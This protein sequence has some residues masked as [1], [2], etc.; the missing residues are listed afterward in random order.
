[1]SIYKKIGIGLVLAVA[2]VFISQPLPTSAQSG[3]ATPAEVTGCR[4]SLKF[5]DIAHLSCQINSAE[6]V[7][8]DANPSD[9]NPNYKPVDTSIFCKSGGSVKGITL[10]ISGSQLRTNPPSN[11]T[12]NVDLDVYDKSG[13]PPCRNTQPDPIPVSL[14]TANAKVQATWSGSNIESLVDGSLLSPLGSHDAYLKDAQDACGGGLIIILNSAGGSSGF[15]YT[16]VTGRGSPGQPVSAYP[17]LN[18]LQDAGSCKVSSKTPITVSGTQGAAPGGGGTGEDTNGDGV[19][20]ENDTVEE[21]TCESTTHGALAWLLCPLI[22]AA[23]TI[24]GE[25]DKLIVGQLVFNVEENLNS[26][27]KK[28]WS[29]VKNIATTIIVIAMLIMVISQAVSWG[30][31]DAY[32]VKKLL[33][34][35]VVVVILMQLSWAL[36]SWAIELSNDAGKG[37]AN[38]MFTPFGGIDQ[39][40]LKNIMSHSGIDTGTAALFNWGL[41]L[42]T[43]GL[44]FLNLPLL[45]LIAY[46]ALVAILIAFVVLIIRQAL[47]IFC[48]ILAPIALATWVLPGTSSYWKLW[49]E[50]FS[51]LLLMFPMIVGIIAAGRIFAWVAGDAGDNGTISFFIIVICV[52]APYVILPKTFQW[53]GR[54]LGNLAGS[55]NDRSKG[56]FDKGRE[57]LKGMSERRRGQHG[58]QYNPDASRMN[59]LYRRLGSGNFM[60]TKRSQRLAI[61]RGDA[62]RKEQDEMA[63]ASVRRGYEAAVE[64]GGI[65]AGKDYLFKQANA[66]TLNPRTGKR[67]KDLRKREAAYRTIIA[68]SSYDEIAKGSE[69]DTYKVD[70]KR[71]DQTKEWVTV[72]NKNRDLLSNVQSNRKDLVPWML[73]E[74]GK[75]MTQTVYD[76]RGDPVEQRVPISNDVRMQQTIENLDIQSL[77]QQNYTLHDDVAREARSGN[78]ASATALKNFLENNAKTEGGRLQLANFF[79]GAEKEGHINNALQALD[80]DL[81]LRGI[82]DASVS[83]G[84]RTSTPSPAPSPPRQQADRG[85]GTGPVAPPDV[86]NPPGS[87]I[88]PDEGTT[89]IDHDEPPR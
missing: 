63:E 47:I 58:E 38:L 85:W 73:P 84:V 48:V 27:V 33:P 4:Q 36:F 83:S 49:H 20:D 64:K 32:T 22:T 31:F 26:E 15:Q 68:T 19:V 43:V 40:N 65:G 69:D 14:N 12:A 37:L 52:F 30:P 24:I 41:L 18:F 76:E 86:V 54:A 21:D 55:L 29:S 25:L 8:V 62:Y 70:G 7:F 35:L 77:A 56:M 61:A 11:V 82:I 72:L 23:D 5:V 79:G 6:V 34:K 80:P 16:L 57:G 28:A 71:I 10:T 75:T 88:N 66:T 13:A 45:L 46:G 60:P 17:E 3:Q 81:S 87:V 50:T 39:M 74:G 42:A 9:N 2:A 53:G 89:R 51:K 59:R 44:V 1:M 67:E 78:T